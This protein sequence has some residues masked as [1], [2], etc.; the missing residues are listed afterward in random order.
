MI[1]LNKIE[2][3]VHVFFSGA[4]D[5]VASNLAAAFRDKTVGELTPVQQQHLLN[6]VSASL[7]EGYSRGLR[8]F[9]AAL[10]KALKE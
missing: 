8:A 10:G 9:T 7:D 2:R 3:C 5:T 1:E 6:L 4:K